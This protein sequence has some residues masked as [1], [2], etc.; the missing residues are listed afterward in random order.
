[1]EEDVRDSL[2]SRY[3]VTAWAGDIWHSS[4]EEEV[5]E[6]DLLCPQL[7]QQRTLPLRSSLVD[8]KNLLGRCG[9]VSV[10]C[11]A[12][13]VCAPLRYPCPLCLGFAPSFHCRPNG[14][15]FGRRVCRWA[16]AT[17]FPPSGGLFGRFI[18]GLVPGFAHVGWDPPDGYC[19]SLVLELLDLSCN[20]RED[21]GA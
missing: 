20:F 16:S 4:G 19:P 18:D 5:V 7:Y 12:L 9:R 3:A 14:V 17:V 21:V 13:C 10:G 2:S 1:M 11:A 6:P 8:L 15:L